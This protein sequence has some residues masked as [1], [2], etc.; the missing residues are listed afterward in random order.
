[1]KDLIKDILLEYTKS[2]W[3]FEKVRDEALKYNTKKEFATKSQQ[4]YKISKKNGWF[5]E[6]TRHMLLKHENWS[7]EKIMDIAKN[8]ETMNQF[9]KNNIKA[10]ASA[11]HNGWLDEI[12]KIMK[13]AYNNFSF[14]QVKNEALKYDNKTDFENGSPS[15]YFYAIKNKWFDEVTNHMKHK[16]IKWTY[17]EVKNIA[18]KYNSKKD[19]SENDRGAYQFAVRQNF[20]DDITKHMKPL[21]NIAK[22]LIYAYEFPDNSVYVGLTFS[23]KER[24]NAHLTNP[25]SS[26][27]KY[28]QETG[29]TPEI[30]ILT[31][32]FLDAEDASKLEVCK[33]EEY[34]LNGWKI[35]NK[36]KGGNLGG[37]NRIWTDDKILSI[38]RLYNTMNDFKKNS[39]Q[40]YSAAGRYQLLDT[41]RENMIKKHQSWD[42]SSL[43]NIANKF[44]SIRDFKKNSLNAYNAS[45]RLG[46]FNQITSHMLD[47]RQKKWTYDMVKSESEKYKYRSELQ[48]NNPSAYSVALRN[49]WLD[50]LFPIKKINQFT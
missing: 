18:A 10:Y 39:P 23:D 24:H 8:Y 13:S 2:K 44:N 11:L 42:L 7:L 46:L 17:D 22:R 34:K 31:D 6:I 1:M 43:Q 16:S 38:S 27:Y 41:I 3:T 28:I 19:F 35:L 49:N 37:C 26:V 20:L 48:K 50:D 33:I 15:H 21:G 25:K 9:K 14:E 36:V 40:T 5:D 4:A 45:M 47:D 32:E 29:V 30:K 12:R